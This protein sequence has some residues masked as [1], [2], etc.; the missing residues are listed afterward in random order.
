MTLAKQDGFVSVI[1]LAQLF[2]VSEVTIRS[3]LDVLESQEL[4][5]RTHG[6]A[7]CSEQ[8]RPG[9]NNGIPGRAE[10]VANGALALID[11]YDAIMI[12]GGDAG[13]SLALRLNDRRGLMVYSDSIDIAIHNGET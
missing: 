10:R 12:E 4:L 7:F 2:Q 3:D 8:R 5:T 11:D 9:R 6:G 13:L 1:E